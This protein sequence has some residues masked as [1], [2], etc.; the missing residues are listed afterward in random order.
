[1]KERVAALRK[2]ELKKLEIELVAGGKLVPAV[3]IERISEIRT[4][5]SQVEAAPFRRVLIL[6]DPAPAAA[7]VVVSP[8]SG[9]GLALEV[10]ARAFRLSDKAGSALV[11]QSPALLRWIEDRLEMPQYALRKDLPA[12]LEAFRKATG[13]LTREAQPEKEAPPAGP[14]VRNGGFTQGTTSP[15]GWDPVDDLTTF[16]VEDPF[17]GPGDRVHGKVLKMDTDVLESEWLKRRKELAKNSR[18]KPWPKTLVEPDRQYATVGATY[19][20]SCY[21]APIPVRK[22]QAYRITVDFRACAPKGGISKIWVRGYGRMEVRGKEEWSR[23]YDSLH[24]LRTDDP[25][26]HTYT[27]VFHPTKNTPHV[28]RVKVMLY[29]YWPR[30]EYRWDN[31]SIVPISDTEYREAK[32]TERSDIK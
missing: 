29:S 18:A 2:S 17:K 1:M 12:L 4:F 22:G 5:L 26:W 21:S 8:L 24:T 30:G 10:T 20:V 19:G 6:G 31:V 25:T 15:L 16:W 28:E 14:M 11:F 7:R 32:K 23:I 27:N 13:G 3:R 9:K